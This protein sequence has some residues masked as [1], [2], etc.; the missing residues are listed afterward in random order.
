MA[1]STTATVREPWVTREALGLAIIFVGQPLGWAVRSIGGGENPIYP[2]AAVLIGFAMMVRT[3]WLFGAKLYCDPV[4]IALPS[5]MVLVPF[6]LLSVEHPREDLEGGLYAIFLA[7]S[8]VAVGL[9]PQSRYESLPR[10]MMIIGL[11]SCLDP[12]ISLAFANPLAGLAGGTERLAVAGNNN[13]LITGTIGS[14]TL[15]SALVVGDEDGNNPLVAL[16]AAVAFTVGL[17]AL[18]MSDKRSDQLVM[19]PIVALFCI[20]RFQ[21]IRGEAKAGNGRQRLIFGSMLIGGITALPALATLFFSKY[22]LLAFQAES[23]ARQ[24]GFLNVLTSGSNYGTDT[25]TA[26][27]YTTILYTYNH[28]DFM[29][30][31]MMYES[32]IQGNGIYTH[33]VYLQAF[34]DLGILGGFIFMTVIVFIPLTL[35]ALRVFMGPLSSKDILIVLLTL[36][37]Q[38]DNLSHGAPYSWEQMIPPLL[39]YLLLFG[40]G[41]ETDENESEEG[42]PEEDRAIGAPAA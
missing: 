36:Y 23:Q 15:I 17:G 5:L 11:A 32:L 13:V 16:L 28:L 24:S 22:A 3:E 4:M 38:A 41:E 42:G 18:I 31:G 9:S 14:V 8:I 39:C 7:G 27:R 37:V 34:Y 25:S 33:L 35:A 20:L 2:I 6:L 21:R 30:H 40:R 1:S 29:G 10:A 26:S 12:F 19:F